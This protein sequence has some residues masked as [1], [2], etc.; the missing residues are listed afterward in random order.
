MRNPTNGGQ[1][2]LFPIENAEDLLKTGNASAALGPVRELDLGG[3]GIRDIAWSPAH[4]EYLIIGGQAND[5]DP[6]PG[7][8]RLPVD[9]PGSAKPQPVSAFDDFKQIPHFHPEA[10][11][12]LRDTATGQYSKEVL[13]VSDDG[14]NPMPQSGVCKDASEDAKSFRAIKVV[15]P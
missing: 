7:V 3:R 13:L 4:Q 14:T 11:V 6:G 15:V 9:R 10:I 1:A 2:L 8:R 5:E 12:P